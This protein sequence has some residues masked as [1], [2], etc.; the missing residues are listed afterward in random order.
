MLLVHPARFLIASLG[1]ANAAFLVLDGE[2]GLSAQDHVRF[3]PFSVTQ[4]Y[5]RVNTSC[6][7]DRLPLPHG[8]V[9][10]LE[11]GLKKVL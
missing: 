8:T 2:E 10:A 9:Y 5:C 7:A 4:T 1:Q 3:K 6:S 11:P